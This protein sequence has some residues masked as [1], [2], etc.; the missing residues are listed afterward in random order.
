VWVSDV[1]TVRAQLGVLVGNLDPDAVPVC[2]ALDLWCEFDDIERRAASAKMLLARRVEA[3]GAWRHEGYR[4]VAEQLAA[5]AG[6]SVSAARSMLETSQ[7][8]AE[9]PKVEQALR[10]GELSTAK[11]GLVAG[12]VEIVPEA[13]DDLLEL[14]KTAPVAKVRDASLRAKASV[15]RDETHARIR[16]ERMLHEY[17]D[18]EGAWV[19]RAR[20]PAE[21]GAAF[22]AAITPII[23]EYFTR[24]CP[25]EDREPREA[26]AFDALVELATRQQPVEAK[27]SRRYLGL[28][29][30]D[31]EAMQ[32]GAVEGDE[33]CEISGLGPIPVRV[34]QELLGDDG[35]AYKRAIIERFPDYKIPFVID[36][37]N[38]YLFGTRPA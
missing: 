3:A 21:A 23:D 24:K 22:R 1:R 4:S 11:V 20:G 18:A 35:A 34:A 10:A 15:G 37:S 17:T 13:V 2:D 27:Q 9:Q 33:V 8:V 38:F 30:V 25:P 31:L 26:L 32:R 16:R 7:R 28:V 29:R 12:A 14:A 19:L 6:T 36:I 5:R